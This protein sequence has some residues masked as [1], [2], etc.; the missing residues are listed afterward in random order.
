MNEQELQ[1]LLRAVDGSTEPPPAGFDVKLRAE[2]QQALDPNARSR[3][4]SAHA[5]HSLTGR[6]GEVVLLST[7]TQTV[8]AERRRQLVYA[9]A[10]AMLV[11]AGFVGWI[12]LSATGTETDVSDDPTT[13]AAPVSVV[14]VLDDP[15]LAC[16]RY[17]E[18]SPLL[19][20]VARSLERGEPV[21]DDVLPAAGDAM[22]ILMIDIASSGEFSEDLVAILR[23]YADSLRQAALEN[24][25]G[26]TDLALRSLRQVQ[27]LNWLP[28]ACSD[29]AMN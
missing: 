26:D 19:L 16:Q 7:T 13:T 4:H 8:A 28:S 5:D 6:D 20:G 27:V 22:E 2:L 29:T 25:A 21:P 18:T 9:V 23:N 17:A 11:V 3:P 24:R 12:Q 1:E 14:P 15:E 10:A